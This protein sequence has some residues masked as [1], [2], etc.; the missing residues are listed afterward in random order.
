M[1]RIVVYET[2]IKK[3]GGSTMNECTLT[4]E[5]YRELFSRLSVYHHMAFISMGQV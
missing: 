1:L 4:R 2:S 3:M 5:F